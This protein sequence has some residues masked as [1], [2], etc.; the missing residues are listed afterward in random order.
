[1]SKSLTHFCSSCSLTNHKIA[2]ICTFEYIRYRYENELVRVIGWISKA[3]HPTKHIIGHIGDGSNDPN[4]SV[5]ALKE[6]M[7]LRIRFQ[8][9]QVH[10]TV[11]QY[12]STCRAAWQKNTNTNESMH[13]EGGPVWQNQ[14]QRIVRT[15]HLSVLMTVHNFSTQYNTE[16][17]W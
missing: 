10:P 4:N 3:W 6:D 2:V 1:M 5:K 8:S 13:S 7:V 12:Y 16:Q 11:L 15:A 17:F 14:I 9:H